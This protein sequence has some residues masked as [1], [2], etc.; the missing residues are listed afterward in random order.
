M[1]RQSAADLLHGRQVALLGGDTAEACLE[2]AVVKGGDHG[3][4]YCTYFT[5]P[6][7]QGNEQGGTRRKILY[8]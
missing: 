3:R 2:N 1:A 5:V 6:E 8:K 7:A 4:L